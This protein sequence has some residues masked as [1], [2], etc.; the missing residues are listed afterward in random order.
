M[1]K[2][3]IFSICLLILLGI[4]WLVVN[5]WFGINIP[6]I[7]KNTPTQRVLDQ[8][9]VMPAG[10]SLSV[11]AD[12]LPGAR[13]LRVTATGDLLVSLPSRGQIMI[14]DRDADLDGVADASRELLGGLNWPHGM[15]FYQDWLYIAETDAIGRIRYNASTRQ[16]NGN[17]DRIITG[18]P[19]G[20]NHWSR[21]LRF[22]PDGMMYVSIGSSCNV[23]EEKDPRRAAILR[24]TPDGKHS[25]IFA[26]GLR[27]TVGF[28]WH[29]STHE[30]YGVD[31]GRDFLGD[32]FPPCEL[33]RIVQGKFYGWPYVNGR[34]IP[35]PDYGDLKQEKLTNSIGPVHEFGA[36]TAPLSIVFIQNVKLRSI[37][38]GDALVALHGS[39]NSSVKTGYKILALQFDPE[40]GISEKD[41]ITGFE[42]NGDVIGRPVDIAEAPDGSIYISDDFTGSVYRL[43]HS[44]VE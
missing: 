29:P 3:I 10:L 28:D 22:G 8:Q 9:M 6:L 12:K 25:E 42:Q 27:N 5:T 41:L 7:R 43:S 30:L 32:D 40:K 14:L 1:K 19:K 38:Q 13:M 33:N 37:I 23:C 36:H 24:F 16:T 31:N 20:G 4:I 17:Y 44:R 39:W 26:S 15:D 21:S 18:L 11:F 35:D 34:Q 2:L